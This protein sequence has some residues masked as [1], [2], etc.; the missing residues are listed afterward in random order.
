MP[1]TR[2][3]RARPALATLTNAD[4]RA[5]R[6]AKRSAVSKPKRQKVDAPNAKDREAAVPSTEEAAIV[7]G[8]DGGEEE[9][10][11]EEVV[12]LEAKVV[13]PS[14]PCST[15]PDI[16]N[17]ASLISSEA[18]NDAVAD[19]DR[20]HAERETEAAEVTLDDTMWALR[21]QWVPPSYEF[22]PEPPREVPSD[23]AAAAGAMV[24]RDAAVGKP[25]VR[26]VQRTALVRI[27][28]LLANV[29]IGQ[30]E[31]QAKQG[32]VKGAAK[33]KQAFAG[34]LALANESAKSF[35]VAPPRKG[36][37]KGG[38][39]A[40]SASTAIVPFGAA[41]ARGLPFGAAPSLPCPYQLL[42][43]RGLPVDEPPSP[44]SM[45]AASAGAPIRAE[46]DA[47]VAL[48]LLG[49]QHPA[50]SDLP[51]PR[52]HQHK[53]EANATQLRRLRRH[54]VSLGA[55]QHVLDGW[56]TEIKWSRSVG[57]YGKHATWYI[58][59]TGRKLSSEVEVA[60]YLGLNPASAQRGGASGST[61]DG[62]AKR[63]SAPPLLLKQSA[64]SSSVAAAKDAAKSAATGA[65]MADLLKLFPPAS[66]SSE[67]APT[68]AVGA[69]ADAK[70]RPS[71]GAA[72]AR[73]GALSKEERNAFKRMCKTR[74]KR[75]RTADAAAA[76]SRD[77]EVAWSAMDGARPVFKRRSGG[78]PLI[79]LPGA[80]TSG[81]SA[82]RYAS[83]GRVQEVGSDDEDAMRAGDAEGILRPVEASHRQ[84]AQEACSKARRLH[85]NRGRK[86]DAARAVGGGQGGLVNPSA[87]SVKVKRRTS[88]GKLGESAGREELL[89]LFKEA[90]EAEE[91]ARD[92]EEDDL[93]DIDANSSEDDYFE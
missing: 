56:S 72:P 71:G 42:A 34:V 7:D 48:A 76:A 66:T 26:F 78:A 61:S 11:E 44:T 77:G 85:D 30:Q 8:G 69:A 3:T 82:V 55:S 16:A 15:Q 24:V 92:V 63:P 25:K 64:D 52:G 51:L 19:A 87:G 62:A 22:V 21:P 39:S 83:P 23:G 86:L 13:S 32:R 43:K 10:E 31:A 93:E 28:Q 1:D 29:D 74:E 67:P 6:A 2:S 53:A 89:E 88:G 14:Q 49:S 54:L 40:S 33:S 91:D 58:T 73:A 12:V 80:L 60:R 70:R 50:W 17:F 45:A 35:L 5:A 79:I 84:Y 68:A 18:V 20:E 37:S 75:P 90:R 65:S 57:T 4:P 27:E 41:P 81:S 46:D 59:P 47:S 9:D 38:A 36:K